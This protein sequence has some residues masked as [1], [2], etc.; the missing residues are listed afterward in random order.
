MNI[1]DVK[2]KIKPD[3]RVIMASKKVIPLRFPI[4]QSET[5]H[6]GKPAGLWYAMGTAWIDWVESEM[7]EWV[8]NWHHVYK[9]KINPNR[10]LFIKSVEEMDRFT[11]M[12]ATRGFVRD[13]NWIAVSEK[14]SGIEI[15][16]YQWKRRHTNGWY[17]TWD[18][19]SGC[20]WA[21]DGISN[22]YKVKV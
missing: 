22:V 2:K 4:D 21:R 6:L 9:I 8:E 12:F 14:Y 1:E 3:D 15:V 7:P 5:H 11:D 10:I 13:I 16:P 20:I 18:V 17:Y 19:A